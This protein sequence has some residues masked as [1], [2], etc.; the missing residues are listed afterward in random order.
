MYDI[1]V[2]LFS[3]IEQMGPW[4][5]RENSGATYWG[6]DKDPVPGCIAFIRNAVLGF[7]S[8]V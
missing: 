3:N 1:G 6:K 2:N 5:I 8:Y 7:V 4:V